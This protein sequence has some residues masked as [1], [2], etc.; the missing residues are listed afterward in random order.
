MPVQFFGVSNGQDARSTLYWNSSGT[1]ILPVQFFGV[2]NGQDARS[3][4]YWNSSGTG[5]LPVMEN[6]ASQK[7]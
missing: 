7:H 1:G 6:E 5:I 4:L 3:T 2:S